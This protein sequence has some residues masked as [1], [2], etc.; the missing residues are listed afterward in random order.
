M[1]E[2]VRVPEMLARNVRGRDGTIY[3]VSVMNHRVICVDTRIGQVVPCPVEATRAQQEL[4]DRVRF[5]F[6]DRRP[7][8]AMYTTPFLNMTGSRLRYLYLPLE[9]TEQGVRALN[10]TTNEIGWWPHEI[11]DLHPNWWLPRRP[12]VPLTYPTPGT[13]GMSVP[14]PRSRL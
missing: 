5:Y 9:I 12:G 4:A 1:T 13:N 7:P 11:A 10:L 8:G 6:S 3:L 2:P 14:S